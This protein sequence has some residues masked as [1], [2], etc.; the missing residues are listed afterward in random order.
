[1]TSRGYLNNAVNYLKSL[2]FD[3]N[4]VMVIGSVALDL[5]GV[6]PP[7]RKIHDI[8]FIIRM[9]DQDW[10]CMKLIEEIHKTDSTIDVKYRNDK[11]RPLSFEINNIIFNIWRDKMDITSCELKDDETG[12]WVKPADDILYAKKRYGRTKDYKDII[13]I[14]NYLSD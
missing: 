10:N 8:D 2:H 14:I 7:D 1:M 3:M 13:R 12:V 4:N 6:L 5:L 11:N 9:N